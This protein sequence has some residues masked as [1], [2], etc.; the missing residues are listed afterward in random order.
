[1]DLSHMKKTSPP[2]YLK[3]LLS[4]A[5][6]VLISLLVTSAVLY[7]NFERIALRQVYANDMDTLVQTGKGVKTLTDM[8]VTLSNQIYGDLNVSRLMYYENPGTEALRTADAQLTSY[9][10]SI[11]Y[12]DSVYVY[13]GKNKT[14]YV[15]SGITRNETREGIQAKE[16]FDDRF[17]GDI[18]G[19]FP[20]YKPYRPIPRNFATAADPESV[21][22]YYTFLMYDAF[23]KDKIGQAVIVNFSEQW[24]TNFMSDSSPVKKS[25][26]LILAQDG[27]VVS[28]SAEYPMMSDLSGL[29]WIRRVLQAPGAGSSIETVRG[30]KYLVSHTGPDI[31]G[32]RYVKLTPRDFI[33]SGINRMKYFTIAIAI[34]LFAAGFLAS[35]KLA[36]RLYVPIDEVMTTLKKLSLEEKKNV[37]LL[38]QI[39][40]RDIFL[41]RGIYDGQTIELK[42]EELDTAFNAAGYYCV[43]LLKIDR[44]LEFSQEFTALDQGLIK[45]AI[46]QSCA[47][48]L[49]NGAKYVILD[50]GTDGIAAI[51]NTLDREN[52]LGTEGL[53]E[54]LRRLRDVVAENVHLSVTLTVSPIEA[55]IGS[56]A[57]IYGET[58]E[59]S[60]YRLYR[61]HGSIIRAAEVKDFS[62]QSYEYPSGTEKRLVSA[63]LAGKI[64]ETKKLYG[65]IIA[66]ANDHAINV[67]NLM[68]ARLVFAVDDAVKT[69]KKFN[70]IEQDIGKDISVAAIT[71]AE[72][73][74]EIDVRFHAVFE[75]VGSI[76]QDRKTNRNEQIVDK[77]NDHIE[78]GYMRQD[79]YI[80]SI[81]EY[82][83]KSPT[84]I[85]HIYKQRTGMTILDKIV[86]VRMTHAK[87]LLLGTDLPIADISER[88]GFSSSS[89][90]FKAF[91]KVNGVTPN[92]FRERKEKDT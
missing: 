17:I 5:L 86:D 6:S 80:D 52:D 77:I 28:D 20:K 83:G 24:I 40:F 58:R 37:N 3:I 49:P 19:S 46:M 10:L 65:E 34:A 4:I 90:F 89:Y 84:Y 22:H 36:K 15:N 76:L 87:E 50:M 21:R 2:I 47:E 18:I 9:R 72:T 51:L 59:A 78:S 23:G 75:E 41:G 25:E 1:M 68:L 44:H 12:I 42:L 8:A 13:N 69:V 62:A 57:S 66:T 92:A 33:L 11:P 70:A 71:G 14:F 39:F 81:A 53:D 26:M 91:R 85:S 74:A 67:F 32:W 88:A 82:L 27:T 55:G 45:N 63:L 54:R 79:L 73:I 30:K 60:L 38:R 64:P 29:P 7:L 56:L 61:G 35:W 31:N 43:I 16:E 48:I